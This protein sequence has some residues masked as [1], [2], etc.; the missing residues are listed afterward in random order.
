MI[1]LSTDAAASST[2]AMSPRWTFIDGQAAL[3]AVALGG[4]LGELSRPGGV[5]IVDAPI[6]SLIEAFKAL[7]DSGGVPSIGIKHERRWQMKARSGDVVSPSVD[8]YWV[9][10][11]ADRETG[12]IFA[13]LGLAHEEGGLDEQRRVPLCPLVF[14]FSMDGEPFESMF[15]VQYNAAAY[16]VFNALC[17]QARGGEPQQY[18]MDPQQ[19]SLAFVLAAWESEQIEKVLEQA[20]T[21]S[22]EDSLAK[23]S[24][25]SIR[26]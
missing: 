24:R 25:V 3:D 2:N 21:G 17:A 7:A 18:A 13:A 14:Y 12:A 1:H 19:C 11:I 26:V 20:A 5:T 23:R 8:P 16:A 9:S 22:V 4:E 10:L 6:E 15:G